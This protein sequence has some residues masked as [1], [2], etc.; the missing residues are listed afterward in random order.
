M[1]GQIIRIKIIMD[2]KMTIAVLIQ[3]LAVFLLK[4]NYN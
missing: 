4:I 3:E 2:D 1:N